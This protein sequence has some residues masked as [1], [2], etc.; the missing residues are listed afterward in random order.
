[1]KTWHYVAIGAVVV[2]AGVVYYRR[3]NRAKVAQVGAPEKTFADPRYEKSVGERGPN[4]LIPGYGSQEKLELAIKGDL[5]S[6]YN[7]SD[8]LPDSYFP[9]KDGKSG[10]KSEAVKG[11]Y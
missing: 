5:K 11:S 1:M 2:V 3:R 7:F 10:G 8:Y 9:K 6:D 4:F